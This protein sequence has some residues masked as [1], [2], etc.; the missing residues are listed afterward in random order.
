VHRG[1]PLAVE[2]LQGI[3]AAAKL[4]RAGKL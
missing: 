4:A 2:E 3:A 1:K